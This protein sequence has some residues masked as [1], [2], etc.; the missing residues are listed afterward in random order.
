MSKFVDIVDNVDAYIKDRHPALVA[1][2][3][4][5]NSDCGFS[6]RSRNKCGMTLRVL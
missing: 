2:S 5:T 6:P 4:V 3:K 1:G